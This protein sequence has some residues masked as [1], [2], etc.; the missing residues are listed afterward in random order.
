MMSYIIKKHQ[1]LSFIY[2]IFIFW[3][4]HIPRSCPRLSKGNTWR[5]DA[6]ISTVDSSG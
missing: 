5:N 2:F 6:E 1:N 4:G 3:K